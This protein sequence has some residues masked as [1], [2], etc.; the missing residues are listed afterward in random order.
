MAS[1]GV[2]KPR[3]LPGEPGI[4]V[5][6]GGDLVMFSVLFMTFVYYR[7]VEP[8]L[9]AQSQTLLSRGL[10]I[11]NTLLLLTSSW[12]V[13]NAIRQARGGNGPLAARLILGAIA[14]GLGFVAIK[15]I[16]YGGKIGEGIG[17]TTDMFFTMYFMLT[18]IHLLHLLIGLGVL[19]WM[20]ARARRVTAGDDISALESGASFWHLVDLLW[21]V[22]FALIYLMR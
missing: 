9:F 20:Q 3:H 2:S 16:E 8:A 12:F 13:A 10:G 14:C 11:T 22:L 6:I 17:L 18:G 21:V 1:V 5:L 15:A 19:T 4:W 7:N